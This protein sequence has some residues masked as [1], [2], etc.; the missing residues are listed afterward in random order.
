MLPKTVTIPGTKSD[1]PGQRDNGKTYVIFPMKAFD[2]QSWVVE[3][4]LALAKAGIPIS[5]DL[6]Q[7]VS[8]EALI[9]PSLSPALG[10]VDPDDANKAINGLLACVKFL[11]PKDNAQPVAIP[12]GDSVYIEEIKTRFFLARE[13]W[14]YH[15]DFF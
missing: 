14:N 15:R 9:D 6:L 4:L 5:E 3:S 7:S 2:G 1:A 13:V 12:P 10:L 8:F 11:P